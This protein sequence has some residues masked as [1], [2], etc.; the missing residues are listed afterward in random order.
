MASNV[1]FRILYVTGP[2]MAFSLDNILYFFRTQPFPQIFD[3]HLTP[4]LIPNIDSW[5]QN[6]TQQRHSLRSFTDMMEAFADGLSHTYSVED[7]VDVARRATLAAR[8]I[9]TTQKLAD[10]SRV[11][12]LESLDPSKLESVH[13]PGVRDNFESLRSKLGDDGFH[14]YL[15]RLLAF[16]THH[17]PTLSPVIERLIQRLGKV[18]QT[19][20]YPST[21]ELDIELQKAVLVAVLKKEPLAHKDVEPDIRAKLGALTY[22]PRG[23]LTGD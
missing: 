16:V 2:A 15:C 17:R 11:F 6:K 23:S 4:Q 21:P 14:N 19:P 3:G 8:T 1:E 20:V 22:V 9:I 7:L 5:I 18:S 12:W 10:Y 13:L